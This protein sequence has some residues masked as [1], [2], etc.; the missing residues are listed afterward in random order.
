MKSHKDVAPLL[1][2]PLGTWLTDLWLQ[3][4]EDAKFLLCYLSV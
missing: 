1:A 3:L 2:K 4:C